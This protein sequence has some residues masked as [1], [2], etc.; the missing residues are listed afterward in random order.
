VSRC[1]TA[2]V[3]SAAGCGG[4]CRA[5]RRISAYRRQQTRW[6]Q[7]SIEC[8]AAL[9][10]V[11]RAVCAIASRSVILPP[12]R[13][14][15]SDVDADHVAH[16]SLVMTFVDRRSF[17][18][19]TRPVGC[20]HRLRLARR[21]SLPMPSLRSIARMVAAYSRFV[22]S[23]RARLRTGAGTPARLRGLRPRARRARLNPARLGAPALRLAVIMRCRWI[24]SCWPRSGC[25]SST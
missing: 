1:A 23:H 11:W 19:Y 10:R 18:S 15:H 2:G 25:V 17:W 22:V 20:S 3:P 16:L 5:G 24:G 8:H 12:I 4:A 14:F 9:P 7:G 21:C 6:A 13:V